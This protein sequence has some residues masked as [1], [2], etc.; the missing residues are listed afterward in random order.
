MWLFAGVLYVVVCLL[1]ACCLCVLLVMVILVDSFLYWCV[2]DSLL[3]MLDLCGLLIAVGRF[4]D[5]LVCVIL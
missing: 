3:E 1:V 4:I 2:L 5:L